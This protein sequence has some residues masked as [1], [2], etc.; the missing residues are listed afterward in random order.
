MN[1]ILIELLEIIVYLGLLFLAFF[2]DFI[3]EDKKP[4]NVLTPYLLGSWA[5]IIIRL[6]ER[7]G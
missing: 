4:D 1:N 5:T 7:G 6:L 2:I 3:S